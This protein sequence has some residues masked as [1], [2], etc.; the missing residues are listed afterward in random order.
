MKYAAIAALVATVAAKDCDENPLS[1]VGHTADDTACAEGTK[2]AATATADAAAIK[3][4]VDATNA[5]AK[6][7]AKC[8]QVSGS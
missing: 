5:L 8:A 4:Y 6:A 2:T 7:H 3:K 1:V